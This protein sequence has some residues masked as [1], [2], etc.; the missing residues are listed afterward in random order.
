MGVAEWAGVAGIVSVL[1][2]LAVFFARSVAQSETREIDRRVTRLEA[3][4]NEDEKR[5]ERIEGKLDRLLERS[6]D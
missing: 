1:G 5:L 2:G 6:K 4:R 3:L